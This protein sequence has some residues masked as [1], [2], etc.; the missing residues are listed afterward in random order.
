MR[1]ASG[2]PESK[3]CPPKCRD[4]GRFPLRLDQLRIAANL[5]CKLRYSQGLLFR[6]ARGRMPRILKHWRAGDVYLGN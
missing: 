3:L 4:T 5:D 2:I 6:G 1:V